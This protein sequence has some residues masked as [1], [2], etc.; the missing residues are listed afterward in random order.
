M[1]VY[2]RISET[3]GLDNSTFWDADGASLRYYEATEPSGA[4]KR[5]RYIMA[6]S[7]DEAWATAKE[8]FRLQR[9]T[10]EN[11]KTNLRDT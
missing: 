7:R 10:T 2:K 11:D 4:D 9:A 6:Y 3:I 8:M 1:A 5:T